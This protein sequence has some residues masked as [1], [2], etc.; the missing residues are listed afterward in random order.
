M[1]KVSS[2]DFLTLG[3]N[4][5]KPVLLAPKIIQIFPVRPSTRERTFDVI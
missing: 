1:C 2:T 5:I 4:N 3:Q